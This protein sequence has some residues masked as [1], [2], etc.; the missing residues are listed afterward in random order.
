[1]PYYTASVTKSLTRYV[2]CDQCG[3]QFMFSATGKGSAAMGSKFTNESR[4]VEDMA[5]MRANSAAQSK[6][7]P[8]PDCGWYNT[9]LVK[10][11][12]RE[13]FRSQQRIIWAVG[14][15]L[16]FMLYIAFGATG[17]LGAEFLVSAGVVITAAASIILALRAVGQNANPN[18][19][20]PEGRV[21]L[22]G[23]GHCWRTPEYEQQIA[24]WRI[25]A[26]AKAWYFMTD[27]QR[28]PVSFKQLGYL[29]QNG[30]LQMTDS[31]WAEGM[32]EWLPAIAVVK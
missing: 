19:N 32:P 18:R 7:S 5:I 8:C 9:T 22:A 10:L 4:T 2:T 28:G 14:G 1:V 15:P 11:Y 6:L 30:Q 24:E 21:P 26:A 27:Q 25:E 16:T 12:Q 29:L 31:V 20:W 23:N 13:R 3:C 17:I